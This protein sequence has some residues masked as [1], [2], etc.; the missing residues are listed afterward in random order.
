MSSRWWVRTNYLWA[1]VVVV[2]FLA[3]GAWL[4]TGTLNGGR[5]SAATSHQQG[6]RVVVN[7]A[8]QHLAGR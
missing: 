2:L 7:S 6:R 4:A 3:L 8:R 1:V 5:V